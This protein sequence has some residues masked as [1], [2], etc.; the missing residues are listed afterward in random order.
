MEVA[1][2]IKLKKGKENQ[3]KSTKK[4]LASALHRLVSNESVHTDGRLTYENL[5]KEAGVSRSTLNR[6]PEYKDSLEKAK[7]YLSKDGKT[8]D[9]I[10]EKNKELKESIRDLQESNTEL[11]NKL[12]LLDKV[13]KQEIL[14][15]NRRIEVLERR[16]GRKNDK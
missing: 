2:R 3:K 13:S 15:L 4:M 8:P 11:K 5:Y 7:K 6:Y 1:K 10:F 16:A 14:I 12:K 9:N